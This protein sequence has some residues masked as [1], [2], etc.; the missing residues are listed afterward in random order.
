MLPSFARFNQIPN[1]AKLWA[2]VKIEKPMGCN[3][4]MRHQL[5]ELT[6]LVG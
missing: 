4:I 3:F 2:N 5:K 6:T 1:L